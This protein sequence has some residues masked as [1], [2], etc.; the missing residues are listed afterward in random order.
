MS[1][2]DDEPVRGGY[3]DA[4]LLAL[5]GLDR[6]RAT[7]RAQMPKP[8]IHHLFGLT[9]VSA[10][11]ASVT[12]TMP[13]SP[14][15]QTSYPGLFFA[16]TAALVADAPL[17]GAVMASLGPGQ[18][19]VTSDLSMNFFRPM[20]AD[21]DRLV[22]RARPIEVGHRLGFVEGMVEDGK[23]R[24]IA[25][26][27]TR[28]FIL[29]ID[30]PARADPPTVEEPT[31]DTPDPYLRPAPSSQISK[32]IWEEKSFL[33]ILELTAGGS[34][35]PPPFAQLF[36][37]ANV[38][39]SEGRFRSSLRPTGWHTSPAGTV[40]GGILAYFADTAMTGALSTTLS[41]TEI[42]A[43][44][45]LRVQFLRPAYPDGRLLTA[46][47]EVVHR[48]RNFAAAQVR[49]VNEDSKTVALG[50]S[51]A[52]IISGRSWGSFVVADEAPAPAG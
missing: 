13:A 18:I 20:N 36:A 33:E 8:P 7:D 21:S 47:A 38:S 2:T 30:P 16:G 31:Y 14:W 11:A 19:A 39:G 23:G 6:M 28:C 22:C 42:V 51:S 40:Y 1:W 15:L 26:C 43:P 25:H 10:G 5:S 9:P 29:S 27:T 49:I 17:G 50:S 45:D 34:I 12:F 35:E 3:P 41:M 46:E 37:I 4:S 32:A 48:G 24:A 44:L 52:V